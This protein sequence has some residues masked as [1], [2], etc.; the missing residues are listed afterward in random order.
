MEKLSN[1][2][3]GQMTKLAAI[4]LRTLSGRNQELVTE[5][6]ELKSKVASYEREKHAEKIAHMME[7]KGIESNTSIKDKVA[8]LLQR[9]DL[10]VIEEAVSMSS[11]QMKIASVAND[12]S[13]TVEGGIDGHADAAFAMGLAT[14]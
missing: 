8:G 4:G 5:I 6:G 3:V 7:A 11:P 2:D 13:V 14:D 10:R 12:G 1:A 9:D